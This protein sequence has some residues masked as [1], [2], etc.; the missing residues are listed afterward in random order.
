MK[1]RFKRE[2]KDVFSTLAGLNMLFPDRPEELKL[3][4]DVESLTVIAEKTTYGRSRPQ[5]NYYRK[6]CRAFGEWAGLTP[7]EMHEEI[8][9][10][11]FGTEEAETK[12][13]PK[14]R[15]AKRSAEVKRD[16]YSLLIDHLIIT[17]AKMGFAIPPPDTEGF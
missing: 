4:L 5:E 8:L 10:I 11:A 3:L 7:D 2:T 13:G 6:W 12:F 9:R 17:A 16:E 14:I 15:P 1:Y